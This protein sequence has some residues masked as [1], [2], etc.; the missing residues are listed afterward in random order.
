MHLAAPIRRMFIDHVARGTPRLGELT[1][2]DA[3]LKAFVENLVFRTWHSSCTSRMGSESDPVAVTDP[4]GLVYGVSGLRACNASIM[5]MV[6]RANTN[7]P[8]IMMA[9]KITDSIVSS[10]P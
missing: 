4:T 1:D 9:E 5:P 8:T 10:Q 7:I 3:A 2:E 6:P